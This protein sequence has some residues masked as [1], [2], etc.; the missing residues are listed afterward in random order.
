M[1]DAL[2]IRA[3]V[4]IVRNCWRTS[5]HIEWTTQH[6][7]GRSVRIS[8]EREHPLIKRHRLWRRLIDRSRDGIR[9]TQRELLQ[10]VGLECRSWNRRGCHN[11]KRNP[12]PLAVEKEEELVANN[13]T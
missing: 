10:D 1:R 4:P 2:A 6:R 11:W 5:A 13:R 12:N 9:S 3:T 7:E 8:V